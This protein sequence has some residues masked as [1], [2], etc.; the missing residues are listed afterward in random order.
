MNYEQEPRPE[1]EHHPHIRD[2]IQRQEKN[3]EDRN[4]HRNREK[5]K[6]ERN[7][8]IIEENGIELKEFWCN[9]C[10]LDFAQI[11]YKQVDNWGLNACYKGKCECGKWVIRYITDKNR[12]PYWNESDKTVA[13]SRVN[14]E[15]LLQPHQSGFNL[16]YKKI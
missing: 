8:D 5:E 3:V 4:I 7:K 14:A 1:I 12:D 6:E 13:L 11:A 9:E 2:L 10:S 16:M 15:D